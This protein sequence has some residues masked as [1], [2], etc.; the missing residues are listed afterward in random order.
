M[1]PLYCQAVNKLQAMAE[2]GAVKRTDWRHHL[3]VRV[4]SKLLFSV[5]VFP[6]RRLLSLSHGA[7][8]E[9]N[10]QISFSL[11]RSSDRPLEGVKTQGEAARADSSPAH[12]AGPADG[13]TL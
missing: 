3:W 7:R 13:D 5:S 11:R 6:G 2:T 12:Q 1:L 4:P 8:T 10:V 9:A